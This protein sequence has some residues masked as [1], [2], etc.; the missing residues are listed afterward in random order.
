VRPLS[1]REI[2]CLQWVALGKT[3]TDIAMILGVSHATIKTNLDAARFKLNAVN[4]PQAVAKAVTLG[5][6]T[7]DVT[8]EIEGTYENFSYPRGNSPSQS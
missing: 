2:E 6:I 4:L 8:R 5:L 3:Y 1:P 7:V